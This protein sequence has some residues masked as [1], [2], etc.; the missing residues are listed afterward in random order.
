MYVWPITWPQLCWLFLIPQ[1]SVH[2]IEPV[3]R[4]HIFFW[5]TAVDKHIW[6][7]KLLWLKLS[8]SV[9]MVTW[10]SSSFWI[11]TLTVV[12]KTDAWYS[13][14]YIAATVTCAEVTVN[15]WLSK[16][17]KLWCIPWTLFWVRTF[18]RH[19]LTEAVITSFQIFGYLKTSTCCFFSK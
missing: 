4:R 1:I 2:Q 14:I 16:F 10:F 7:I 3:P 8:Y 6:V 13:R 5:P 18:T 9:L 19:M 12:N 17:S 15:S 11:T